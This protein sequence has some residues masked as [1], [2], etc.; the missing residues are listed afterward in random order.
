MVTIQARRLAAALGA[1]AFLAA[2]PAATQPAG[3]SPVAPAAEAVAQ[4]RDLYL[5]FGC[6]QCHNNNGQ[7]GL[8]GPRLAPDTHPF[9]AF[10]AVVRYPA[11]RMPAYSAEQLSADQL[12]AI[13]AYLL[14]QPA[15]R[16]VADIPLLADRA[17]KLP[18][19]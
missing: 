9:E 4:G 16:D 6:A 18:A 3:D 17:K 8:A 11:M 2:H 13:H 10:E 14:S 12:R 19:K 15:A 7:G 1:A 5:N